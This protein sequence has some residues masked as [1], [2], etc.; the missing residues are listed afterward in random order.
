MLNGEGIV[1]LDGAMGTQLDAK[2]L[3][4]R[5]RANL[6]APQ[7]V[8]E[9]HRAYLQ[10]GSD[11]VIANTLT[12]NRVYVET[13]NVGV[14][15]REVNEAGARLAREAA[16]D[17]RCVL[18]DMSST[19][20]L[21]EPYGTYTESQFH[22][23]FR[24]Q[25]QV[26]AEAGVDGLI[27]ETVFDLREA[28]CALRACKAA[29]ELPVIVSIAFQTD[30]HGGRTMMGDTAEQC[31]GQ[32]ADAG[33]DVIGANCGDLDPLQMSRVITRLRAVTDLPIAAQPNAGRPQL[34]GDRTVFDMRPEPFSEGIAECIRTGATI[35]GGC[36]GTTPEHIEAVRRRLRS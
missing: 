5:G 21:L 2:G 33:A 24:E 1:L 36:C 32:L 8:V 35:V 13:H 18:G 16:G 22:D 19:G 26:L 20:Q 23:A 30:A 34:I 12:M 14:S 4:G 15:T 9:V 17:S 31:A 25:A 7:A 10:A 28:L 29:C 11:A 3:M 27:V 6:D